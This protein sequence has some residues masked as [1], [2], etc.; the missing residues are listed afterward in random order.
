[1]EKICTKGYFIITSSNR[2]KLKGVL[3]DIDDTLT[4]HGR[5]VPEAFVMLQKLQDRDIRVVPVTGR[6]G[7]WAD[8]I[9]RVWPVDGVVGENG[10]LWY[11][12]DGKKLQRRFS[13]DEETRP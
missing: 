9:A 1:M 2:P 6:P 5:L 13:Q 11:W 10:G 3:C 8:Q 12:F 7:G 4:L